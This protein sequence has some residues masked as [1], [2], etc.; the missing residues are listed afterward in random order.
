MS[1]AEEVA[2]LLPQGLVTGY[3]G[4]V[5]SI[6]ADGKP[7]VDVRGAQLPVSANAGY[8]PTPGDNVMLMRNDNSNSWVI[9]FK[10]AAK[11][12]PWLPATLLNGW[13]DRAGNFATTHFRRRNTV[14][15]QLR[16]NLNQGTNYGD[17]TSIIQIPFGYWPKYNCTWTGGKNGGAG[18]SFEMSKVDGQ[19]RIYG[20]TVGNVEQYQVIIPLD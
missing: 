18:A 12:E 20:H 11:V 3:V 14:D 19:I 10:V 1:L 13:T 6:G 5:K 9:A 15:L 4:V 17:G 16:A 7:V 8:V 2:Q